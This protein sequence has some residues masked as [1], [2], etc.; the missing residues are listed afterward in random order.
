MRVLLTGGSGF[1]GGHIAR[2]LVES[3]HDL[4]LLVRPTSDTSFV[5]DLPSERSVGDLRE[6]DSLRA[7]CQGVDA[8]VHSAAVLRAAHPDGF[9]RA[10]REG[11]RHLAEA[12]AESGVR[13][14]VYISSL[15]A[16]GPSPNRTAESPETTPHPVSAY[17]RSK[18]EGERELLKFADH[19][20]IAMLRPPLVYGP[21]DTGLLSFFWMA[22]RGFCVRLG[23][24]SRLVDLVYGPDLAD[25]TV[26]I[27]AAETDGPARNHGSHGSH[28]YHVSDPAGPFSWNDMLAELGRVAGRRLLIPSLSPG[29]FHG[30]ARCS[31]WWAALSRSE[32]V[33]DRARVLEMRQQA[34]LCDPS[35]L[36]EDTGW[37]ARTSLDVGLS[38]TMS[39]YRKHGWV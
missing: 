31:E 13:R 36:V 32:P 1:V 33:L 37:Q 8:V 7:A 26:A 12:A 3:G 14:I 34:W 28:R 11:T 35:S 2:A 20:Q 19:M 25:A 27:L 15:A 6:A 9:M 5:D 38:E 24:G 17:G 16:Q 39:W 18:L 23:D 21:A 30:I 29:V 22:R 10:N 4:R